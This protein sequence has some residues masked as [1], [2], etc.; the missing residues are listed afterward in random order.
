MTQEQIDAVIL[1]FLKAYKAWA[2]EDAPGGGAFYAGF[3]LCANLSLYIDRKAII[4]TDPIILR[5][6]FKARLGGYEYP[7]SSPAEYEEEF[8]MR[9]HHRNHARM[10]WVN[11]QIERMEK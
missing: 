3:G 9:S 10:A 7:F 2:D 5:D 8:H 1:Y 4:I 6:A 11:E